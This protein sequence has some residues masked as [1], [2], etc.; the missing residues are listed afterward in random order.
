MVEGVTEQYGKSINAKFIATEELTIQRVKENPD[1]WGT[2]YLRAQFLWFTSR[3]VEAA[4]HYTKALE[5]LEE[6]DVDLREFINERLSSIK[7]E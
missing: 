7:D 2:Q 3:R 5:L 6:G 4:V 1:Y